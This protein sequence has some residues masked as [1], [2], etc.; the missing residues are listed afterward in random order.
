MK[1]IRWTP[2]QLL[3]HQQRRRGTGAPPLPGMAPPAAPAPR[4]PKYGGK[5]VDQGGIKF[6]SK[7]EARRWL[8]LEE[9]Q[10]AGLISVLQRQ[11]AFVLAPAVLLAGEKRKKPALRYFADAVYVQDGQVVVEDTKSR[12]TRKL[13]IYRAK[14]HLMKTVLGLDIKET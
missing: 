8:V 11:V 5:K 9:M 3:D 12:P 6:D 13:A 4:A 1:S 2:E 14:K 7:K 10:R